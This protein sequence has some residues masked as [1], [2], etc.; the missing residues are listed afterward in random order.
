MSEA[1]THQAA[2]VDT[3]TSTSTS[4]APSSASAANPSPQEQSSL[5]K[6]DTK[7]QVVAEEEFAAQGQSSKQGRASATINGKA[8][9]LDE[10]LSTKP[11]RRRSSG[12]GSTS[13]ER[14]PEK[15]NGH[16]S[17]KEER[18]R[19]GMNGFSS[20][21]FAK[22]SV[23][24]GADK[25]CKP[26]KRHDTASSSSCSS[27]HDSSKE[28]A[29]RQSDSERVSPQESVSHANMN[30][31]PS[32]DM[33]MDEPRDPRIGPAIDSSAASPD[34]LMNGHTQG[35]TTTHTVDPSQHSASPHADNVSMS[36]RANDSEGAARPSDDKEDVAMRDV[37]PPRSV[38]S[39][40]V[41]ETGEQHAGCPRENADD[42]TSPRTISTQRENIPAPLDMS[43]SR[44]PRG[45]VARRNGAA[46]TPG[47]HKR[48]RADPSPS[49]NGESSKRPRNG[50]ESPHVHTPTSNNTAGV[51]S[52][53]ATT[54]RD[55]TSGT[56]SRSGTGTTGVM[57][58]TQ[59]DD[60]DDLDDD[61]E[62]ATRV[63]GYAAMAAHFDL[64]SPSA[65]PPPTGL[66]SGEWK[67]VVMVV[68]PQA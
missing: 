28:K 23:S 34:A 50:A 67:G 37:G 56:S 36:A 64:R 35:G 19:T 8:E 57:D 48:R 17:P 3:D 1:E 44:S 39:A 5:A 31:P 52:S 63:G 40:S 16:V 58:L 18:S 66:L 13:L 59:L 45:D 65:S 54:R 49:P 68:V 30:E 51:S 53:T 33:D 61:E 21:G 43:E 26:H 24:Y 46:T 27:S 12:S 15:M 9:V 22:G 32:P 38:S 47:S 20:H 25:E 42:L 14:E 7:A 55:T 6:G 29:P 2:M 10:D 11:G 4:D 62:G 60:E 41:R